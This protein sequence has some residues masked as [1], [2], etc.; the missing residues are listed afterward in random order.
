[1]FQ[2][3]SETPYHVQLQLKVSKTKR[4]SLSVVHPLDIRQASWN[5]P[6][7][8]ESLL[9]PTEW[10]YW[11][12]KNKTTN[13]WKIELTFFDDEDPCKDND[14]EGDDEGDNEK[15]EGDDEG[16]KGDGEGE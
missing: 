7:A 4:K 15:D 12:G 2:S 8:N 6:A 3:A 1:M 9:V 13:E 10:L 14:N 5:I 11:A 16:D